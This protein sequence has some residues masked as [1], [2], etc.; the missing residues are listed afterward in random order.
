M[1][2]MKVVSRF[3]I[4]LFWIGVFDILDLMTLQVLCRKQAVE[5]TDPGIGHQSNLYMQ[6]FKM[7]IH[8]WKWQ[9]SL[10]LQ[11]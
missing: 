6:Q 9:Q 10:C 3:A 11:P 2:R 4:V 7:Q 5:R 8:D 1:K